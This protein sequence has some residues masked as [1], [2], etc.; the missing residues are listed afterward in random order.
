METSQRIQKMGEPALLK[1]YPLVSEA[2]KKGKKV[3]FLNIG[4]PDIKTPAGFLD[5]V[6]CI[7]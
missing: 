3:Y 5:S 4:Q 1:Y 6:N 2:Q 7:D